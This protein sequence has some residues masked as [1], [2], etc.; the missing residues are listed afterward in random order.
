[1]IDCGLPIRF[2][3]DERTLRAQELHLFAL[4]GR[5][6]RL[7]RLQEHLQEALQ[8]VVHFQ[9]PLGEEQ[10]EVSGGNLRFDLPP[11]AGQL[12]LRHRSVGAG[13]I[14]TRGSFSTERNRLRE[15]DH[16]R[17]GREIHRRVPELHHQHR[18]IESPGRRNALSRS[19][20]ARLCGLQIGI[21]FPCLPEQL[22][23][24]KRGG[25]CERKCKQHCDH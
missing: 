12:G 6:A 4:A 3:L 14:G 5:D 2:E 22:R 1:M 25:R 7:R 16:D 10:I 8:L 24:A 23:Q 15:L 11:F 18:V 20:R 19:L 21:L 17:D 13:G 9:R